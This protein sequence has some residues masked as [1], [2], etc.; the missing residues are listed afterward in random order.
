MEKHRHD[1]CPHSVYIR[2]FRLLTV[3]IRGYEPSFH[4]LFVNCFNCSSFLS[5]A[6][7]SMHSAAS[8]IPCFRSVA[9]PDAVSA[10]AAF[11]ST[12]SR[13]GPFLPFRMSRVIAALS[14]PSPPLRSAGFASRQAEVRGMEE[15]V[16]HGAVLVFGHLGLVRD[17]DLVEPVHAVDDE[18]VLCARGCPAPARAGP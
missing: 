4:G 7:E 13:Q 6:P 18:G 3:F 1:L 10:A 15:V 16:L 14:L 12:M 9:R 17:R 8:V 11:I 5:A 2:R